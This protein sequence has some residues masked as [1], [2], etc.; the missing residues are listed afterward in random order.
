VKQFLHPQQR[1]TTCAMAAIRT[2]LHRQFGVQLAEAALVVL[3]ND[4]REPIVKHGSSTNEMRRAVRG[5]SKALNL[6]PPWT[7]RVRTR[8]TFRMLSW[9]VKHGRWPIAQVFVA[10]QNEYHA[11]V[12]TKVERERIQYYD[13]A[14]SRKLRWMSRKRFHAWWTCP[15]TGQ[16]WFSVI[17]GGTLKEPSSD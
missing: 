9:A 2:V 16:T 10:S 1:M 12:V 13:P 17:N 3:G 11:I 5:A 4:P 14:Y 8:G 7:L 6:G 15:N